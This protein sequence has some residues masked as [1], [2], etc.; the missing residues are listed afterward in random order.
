MSDW[1]I[2][3]FFRSL[4]RMWHRRSTPSKHIAVRRPLP[5]ILVTWAYCWPSSRNTSS[6]FIPSF[7]F[8][9]R[10]RFLPPFPLFLGI[11]IHFHLACLSYYYLMSFRVWNEF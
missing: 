3:T 10:R 11:L 8:F 1:A 2:H 7:S 5:N 6:R 9:P 4:P